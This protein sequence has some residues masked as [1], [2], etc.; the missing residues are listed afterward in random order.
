MP[1]PAPGPAPAPRNYGS[2]GGPWCPV[3]Q[4]WTEVDGDR[5]MG[6]V[7]VRCGRPGVVMKPP[8]WSTR[9]RAKLHGKGLSPE[10]AQ[11]LFEVMRAAVEQAGTPGETLQ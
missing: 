4:K 9:V 7:C 3:C 11:R 1:R 10:E 5:E 2:E 6:N 8:A